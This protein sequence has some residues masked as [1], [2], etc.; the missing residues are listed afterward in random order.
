[1]KDADPGAGSNA[2][3]GVLYPGGSCFFGLN[4]G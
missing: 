3:D 2:L 1:M 4:L